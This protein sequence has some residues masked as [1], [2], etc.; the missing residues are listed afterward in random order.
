MQTLVHWAHLNAY[1]VVVLAYWVFA[2][3][4]AL[5]IV[6]CLGALATFLARFRPPITPEHAPLPWSTLSM[7]VPIK[8]ADDH[9]QDHLTRLV[10]S[11]T[12]L[13][14][15][16]LIAMESEEDEAYAIAQRVA[17]LHP[18]IRVRPLITG[19]AYGRLGKQHNLAVAVAHAQGE[20]IGSMDADVAV[21]P[22]HLASVLRALAQPNVGVAYC[23]PCYAGGGPI[24]GALVAVYTNYCLSPN[25]GALALSGNQPFTIG[26][27]WL[28]TR[29]TLE[30][31]GGLGQFGDTVSDDAAIGA[32][33]A[34]AG[35]R[36]VL[37]PRTVDI[38]FE[39]LALTGG[40]R[41]LSK[42]V[43][44]LRAE[45]LGTYL[46][47]VLTWHP[48]LWSTLALLAGLGLHPR[49]P[50][51]AAMALALLGAAVVARVGGGLLLD[52]ACYHRRGWLPL[53][54]IPYELFIAPVLF[55]AGFVRRSIVWRGHR[56]WIGPH[57][58]IRRS[59]AIG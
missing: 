47:L 10:T 28:I 58:K 49:Y 44:M 15:E 23:L 13:A 46:L 39:P 25:L 51:L 38:P 1:R 55:G 31:I 26:S 54:L 16:Y 32:A 27:L 48:I 35:L 37:T 41:H 9:T 7:I 3:C 5:G 50:A 24:G 19:P 52:R 43:A 53:A 18:D 57:G 33:V 56:Y 30:R 29:P 14:T 8:G 42:W 12:P 34:R 21:T 20:V 6:G 2:I 11:E 4:G 36:N 59:Q 45:G 17:A 22:D 40:V